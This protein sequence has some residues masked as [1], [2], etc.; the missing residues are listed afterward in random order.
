MFEVSN[1]ES[2]G[3]AEQGR[4]AKVAEA[5]HVLLCEDL[6]MLQARTQRSNVRGGKR[7]LKC[8]QHDTIRTV[9]DRVHILRRDRQWWSLYVA[10]GPLEGR[11]RRIDAPPASRLS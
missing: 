10:R 4:T 9:A 7:S 6:S 5:R 3:G 1:E 2:T 11:A 8:V